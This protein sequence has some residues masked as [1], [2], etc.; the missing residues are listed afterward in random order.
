MKG[1][2][3]PTKRE[4]PSGKGAEKIGRTAIKVFKEKDKQLKRK[5]KKEKNAMTM[6]SKNIIKEPEEKG[7]Q[8]P[9]PP[10][11]HEHKH[12]EPEAKKED[13][14]EADKPKS[15][16][17]ENF[18][19]AT[20]SRDPARVNPATAGYLSPAQAVAK[21]VR[22]TELA[23]GGAAPAPAVKGGVKEAQD[24]RVLRVLMGAKVRLQG[25]GMPELD[26]ELNELIADLQGEGKKK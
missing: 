9:P 25:R 2:P 26:V 18:E 20:S 6:T 12:H 16:F 19:R 7:R 24:D 5:E 4:K 11:G 13:K 23:Q 21:E 8:E 1:R 10:K 17:E 22:D 14:K 15:I 3:R